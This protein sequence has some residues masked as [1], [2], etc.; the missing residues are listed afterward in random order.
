MPVRRSNQLSYEATDVGSWSFAGSN[1][2]EMHESMN[3]IIFTIQHI[4][5]MSK[6]GHSA[7]NICR[8]YSTYILRY[9]ILCVA[10]KN[11]SFFSFFSQ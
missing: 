4:V 2:P 3:E 5:K 10:E 11:G 8:A 6:Y 7:L 9:V 1:V